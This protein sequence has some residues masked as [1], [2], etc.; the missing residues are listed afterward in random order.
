MSGGWH[1][2][3]EVKPACLLSSRERLR[4][5]MENRVLDR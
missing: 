5:I 1:F 4:F 2:T 3:A